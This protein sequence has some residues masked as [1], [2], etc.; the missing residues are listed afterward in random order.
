M[1]F[2]LV[3][4]LGSLAMADLPPDSEGS[5]KGGDGD[6]FDGWSPEG[7]GYV[8]SEA[9]LDWNPDTGGGE[10]EDQ[11]LRGA[12]L[13]VGK[14]SEQVMQRLRK[15]DPLELVRRCAERID[16]RALLMDTHRLAVRAVAY[17]AYIAVMEEYRGVPPLD[18]FILKQIDESIDSI[19]EEDWAS[20]YRREP[21]EPDDR[22]YRM[23]SREA[24]IEPAM[25]RRASLALNTEPIRQ[26]RMFY[27]VFVKNKPLAMVAR[28][29]ALGIK[30][31][32]AMI[33]A[34]LRK[35]LGEATWGGDE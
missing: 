9:N 8:E 33:K 23:I 34:T 13:L 17:V 31:A 29:N 24:G 35:V 19:M 3:V 22:R 7:F 25:A 4:P 1:E 10:P 27:G 5:S 16:E 14:T 2:F 32:K 6:V 28:E 11:T 30:E 18:V 26:R 12:A 15:G 20:E 21:L